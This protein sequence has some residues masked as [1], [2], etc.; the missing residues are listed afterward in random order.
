MDNMNERKYDP[1]TFDWEGDEE[2][3]NTSQPDVE[4]VE[5]L[6]RKALS[7]TTP[8][9]DRWLRPSKVDNDRARIQYNFQYALTEEQK[10]HGKELVGDIRTL[11][12][13]AYGYHDHPLSHAMT[14]ISEDLVVRS[15]GDEPFVSVYGN[16]SRHRRM[17][18]TG[19]YT[20]TSRNVPHD[21][22]RNRGQDEQIDDID[23]FYE[24]R[25]HLR[26]RLFLATHAL[27]YMDL[28]DVAR[29]LS[30]NPDAE[31]HAIVHRHNKSMG[32]LTKG[33]IEY[34]V[35]NQGV[36]V[37]TN[38]KT[39]LQ[40]THKTLEPL[41]HV[42]SA[43][44]YGGRVG[45]SW[46]INLLAGDNYHIKF[47]LCDPA[48]CASLPDPWS[49]IDTD[50]EVSVRGDVTVYRILGFEWY[51]YN[52]KGN[53]VVLRDVDLFDRLRRIVAGRERTP[54]VKSDL[55]SMCRRLANKNDII[56][57]HQGFAHEVPPELMADYVN[58][59]FYCDVQHELEIA[60]KYHRENKEAVDALNRYYV[61]GLTPTD[62]TGIA[63]AGR[64]VV[65]PFTV[66][67]GLLS[68]HTVGARYATFGSFHAYDRTKR[69]PVLKS[70]DRE[71]VDRLNKQVLDMIG[72]LP[73]SKR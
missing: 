66:L 31:F 7:V 9:E 37:Q 26:Y 43:K 70:G 72:Q 67:A 47:V 35:D 64:A 6:L 20:V 33:E 69:P 23:L 40:Y 4:G 41:F 63:R 1:D 19:A 71:L 53:E 15:F 55:M 14:E 17:G 28:E 8:V 56:S 58:A 62:L 49:L 12:F 61:E 34:T 22:F 68:D 46:D 27:Y 52:S 21:W 13:N 5:A 50:R 73:K 30:G 11:T 16:Q 32:R 38:P 48:R 45:L 36:V 29:M 60:L 25:S 65:A 39:G 2:T 44:L 3:V 54:R 18:H 51:V 42:D 57:I 24:R 10:E 59:A